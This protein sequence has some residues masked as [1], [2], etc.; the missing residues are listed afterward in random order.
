LNEYEHKLPRAGAAGI[1]DENICIL[2]AED[3]FGLL[4]SGSSFYETIFHIIFT[5]KRLLHQKEN[6]T[7]STRLLNKTTTLFLSFFHLEK[8]TLNKKKI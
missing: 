2:R 5:S 7:S 6:K 1:F 8:N 4:Y 3:S